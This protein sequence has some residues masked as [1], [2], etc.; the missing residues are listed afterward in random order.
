MRLS[1][2]VSDRDVGEPQG[3]LGVALDDAAVDSVAQL[4]REV[5]SA[6]RDPLGALSFRP[7][8]VLGVIEPR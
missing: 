7:R 4:E 2:A 8:A 6:R 5:A 3:T 1:D